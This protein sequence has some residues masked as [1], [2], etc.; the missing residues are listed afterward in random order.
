MKRINIVIEKTADMYS[1]YAENVEGI[2]GGGGTA[3]EAKQSVLDAIKILKENNSEENIPE[4]LKGDYSIRYHFDVESLLQYYKGM[5]SNPAIEKITGIN[6]KLIH[7]YSKGLKKPR[8]KQK[9]KI[10]EGLHKLGRELLAIE[11]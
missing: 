10:E 7:Q 3:E 9:K 2:Y 1:S 11:L 5:L 8:Q 6:Q 4:I